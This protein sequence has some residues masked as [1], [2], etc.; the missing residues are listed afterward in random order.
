MPHLLRRATLA[1]AEA[2]L[3]IYSLYIEK[4]AITFELETP[5]LADFKT[6]MT[7]IMAKFP[8]LV[9]EENGKI[10]GYAYASTFKERLAYRW[11]VE[12]TI[13][14]H[15]K[16]IGLGLGKIL[17]TE[18]LRQLKD[19]NILN[20]IGVIALPNE[21]SVQLHEKMG[22]VESGI[23]TQVGFKLGKWWDV[24]FWQLSWDKP[25]NPPEVKHS[26]N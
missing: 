3:E 4:T 12:S 6:R 16:A 15:E 1:D 10:L 13:Y 18:L 19:M 9:L 2:I 11:S 21:E 20:V 5:T 22:F 23:F 17:Y 8:Y 7:G 26:V 14:L 25:K 24:G